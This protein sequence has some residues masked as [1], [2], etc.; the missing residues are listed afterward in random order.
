MKEAIRSLSVTELSAVV[1][2]QETKPIRVP[3]APKDP[4]PQDK[5]T[6]DTST[7]GDTGGKGGK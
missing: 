1:G 6:S 4:P 3:T 5:G 7:K 2:G